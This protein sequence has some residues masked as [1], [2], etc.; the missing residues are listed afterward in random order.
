MSSHRAILRLC[1]VLALRRQ[2]PS[3]VMRSEQ[4]TT[5]RSGAA[6]LLLASVQG[7]AL[8]APPPRS[9][10]RHAPRSDVVVIAALLLRACVSVASL[11]Q[12]TVTGFLLAGIGHRD[13]KNAANFLVVDAESQ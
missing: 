5:Q 1:S 10:G 7:I 8:W 6:S 11:R 2:W 13:N 4:R 9:S 3:S 12:D